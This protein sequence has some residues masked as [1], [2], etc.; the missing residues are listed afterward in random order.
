[1]NENR[2]MGRI[3]NGI[4]IDHVPLGKIWKIA[5]LLGI[6]KERE[7]RVSLGDGY[8]S[9]KVGK[10]GVLKIE[11]ATISDYQLNLIALV[12][13]DATVSIIINGEVKKKIKAEIP[14]ILR[15]VVKCPN[16]NCIS[17]DKHEKIEPFVR[18]NSEKGF[19]CHYCNREFGEEEVGY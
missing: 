11:G 7:G 18:Y 17:N 14:D 13:K 3:E 2:I 4:A 19:N 5:E 8:E 15:G 12:A 1:M 6:G 10:K 16:P 9:S